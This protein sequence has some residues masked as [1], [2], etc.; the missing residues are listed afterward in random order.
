MKW[1]PDS[2][3]NGRGYIA[4]ALL[5]LLAPFARADDWP[6]W[7]GPTRDGVWHETGIVERFDG[8]ELKPLWRARISSGYSGPTVA[9]GRAYVTDRV[10]RPQQQERVHC[11]DARSG[12]PL[13]THDYPCTYQGISYEAGPRAA[14]A[15]ADGR[16]Y[17][18]GTMGHLFC[19]DDESGSVLWQHDLAAEYDIRFDELVWGVSASPVVEDGLVIVQ[20]GGRQPQSCLV[21]FDAASGEERWRALDDRASYSAPIVIQQAGRKVLACWTG[22]SVAGLDP[23]SGEV[24]WRVPFAPARMVL[25]I[26]SPVLDR[27]RLFATGFYDGSMMIGLDAEG[28]RRP[29]ASMLWHRRGRSEQDTDALHSII[30]TPY[31]ADGH[32]YGV[33]SYGEFRCL[34]AATGDRVWESDKPVPIARWSTVHMVRNGERIFMF[35]ERGDLVICR[36]SPQG[37]EE[38][39][40]AKLIEPTTVQLPQRG[41][42]CWSH[43]A[44]ANRCVFARNDEELVCASLSE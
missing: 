1:Y 37:Y 31:M 7:R 14:V 20:V 11:F 24:L 39:D 26:A 5:F 23:A 13:W 4:I 29:A 32:V 36:L 28:P 41:G 44:Y 12:E 42:V 8:P 16:A 21:A 35:T 38:I 17:S 27:D 10:A 2:A 33:D 15:I 18:L 34:E 30:S 3:T 40:R 6:C 43:P 25:A 19:L 22:D 9:D